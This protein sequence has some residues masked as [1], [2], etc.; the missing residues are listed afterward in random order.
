M[1]ESQVNYI[2][3]LIQAVAENSAQAVEI[4]AD[5]QAQFNTRIQNQLQGTVWQAGGCSSWYQTKDGKNFSVWPTYSWKYWLETRKP[6][7]TD[8]HLISTVATHTKQN[9]A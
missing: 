5:V 8:Y 9:V 2:M 6:K 4:K 7:L 1:I 3:Q